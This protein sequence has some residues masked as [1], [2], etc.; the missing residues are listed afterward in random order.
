M[1]ATAVPRLAHRGA[2]LVS[3]ALLAVAGLVGPAV[4]APE[5]FPA[6][7]PMADTPSGVAVDKTGNVY[8][9]VPESGRGVIW[10]YT[11][12]AER[13]DERGPVRP[14]P[15]YRKPNTSGKTTTTTHAH[16]A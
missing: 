7:I 3:I 11:P 5:Q 12:D 8:V 9:S 1:R 14:P 16:T 15:A 2:M 6:F 10:K 13:S 4:V